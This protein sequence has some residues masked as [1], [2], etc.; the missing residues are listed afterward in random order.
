MKRNHIIDHLK[1]EVNKRHLQADNAARTSSF[2]YIQ[3]IK[4]E[5]IGLLI[6]I[7]MLEDKED[8]YEL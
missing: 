1:H 8:E 3:G 5:I 6:A 2:N 4:G 7:V